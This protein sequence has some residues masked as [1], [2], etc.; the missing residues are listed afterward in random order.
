MVGRD[1]GSNKEVKEGG[2]PAKRCHGVEGEDNTAFYGFVRAE[3]VAVFDEDGT[4]S[5]VL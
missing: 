2:V 1:I 3:S 5:F 4:V